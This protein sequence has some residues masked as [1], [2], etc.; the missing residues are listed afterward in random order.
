[1]LWYALERAAKQAIKEKGVWFPAKLVRWMCKGRFLRCRL[2]SGRML[3]YMDP[4]ISTDEYG[5][6]IT[7]MGVDTY[8]KKWSRQKTFGGKLC[9]NV[10]S[11]ISRDI[12]TNAMLNLE[13]AGYEVVMTVHD[14][15]IS[16]VPKDFGS[17]EEFIEIM[18]QPIGWAP[19]C[20]IGA[21]GWR[22]DRYKK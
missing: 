12:M 1:M 16:E 9:E 14:E 20:A 17:V 22:A 4:A 11:A 13:D 19:G 15:I 5:E 2:P 6:G 3:W 10:V 21:E 7:F 8:T 18:T